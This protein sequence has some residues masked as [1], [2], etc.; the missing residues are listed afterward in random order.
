VCIT[1]EIGFG[2]ETFFFLLNGKNKLPQ[3]RNGFG[4]FNGQQNL[5]KIIQ[6]VYI[7]LYCQ[8]AKMLDIKPVKMSNLVIKPGKMLVMKGSYGSVV[9]QPTGQ[10]QVLVSFRILSNFQ[11]GI[12]DRC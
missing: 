10:G 1:A 2:C 3:S 5:L 4:F 6:E 9:E 12:G 11:L 8:M 7:L